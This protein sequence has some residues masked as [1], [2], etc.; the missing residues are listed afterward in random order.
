MATRQCPYCGEEIQEDAQKCRYCREWLIE[1]SPNAKNAIPAVFETE[2]RPVVLNINGSL[3]PVEPWR[4]PLARLQRQNFKFTIAILALIPVFLFGLFLVNRLVEDPVMHHNIAYYVIYLGGLLCIIKGLLSLRRYLLNFEVTSNI[5][6]LILVFI[7]ELVLI[8]IYFVVFSHHH[9][10]SL[11]HDG[12]LSPEALVRI[13]LIDLFLHV[14]LFFLLAY[15]GVIIGWRLVRNVKDFVGGLDAIG[16]VIGVL[17]FLFFGFVVL[18][19]LGYTIA[20][21]YDIVTILCAVTI[22]P[23]VLIVL[24]VKAILYIKHSGYETLSGLLQSQEPSFNTIHV[25]IVMVL[26]MG[27]S[28]SCVEYEKRKKTSVIAEEF[29]PEARPTLNDSLSMGDRISYYYYMSIPEEA[30]IKTN[31]V[32]SLEWTTSTV[33]RYGGELFE[34]KGLALYSEGAFMTELLMYNQKNEVVASSYY[35]I[36]NGTFDQFISFDCIDRN[37]YEDSFNSRIDNHETWLRKYTLENSQLSD[38]IDTLKFTYTYIEDTTLVKSYLTGLLDKK[39]ELMSFD[40]GKN[41]LRKNY[42]IDGKEIKFNMNLY[43]DSSKVVGYVVKTY[44]NKGES[45]IKYDLQY[46]VDVYGNW[47]EKKATSKKNRRAILLTKRKIYY[48]N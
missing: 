14:F 44:G 41:N 30:S 46:K 1:N 34:E 18:N 9:A 3:P 16:Y 10:S 31:N 38:R 21:D 45:V 15:T 24:F 4:P 43:N 36:E 2:S 19:I 48:K 47:I 6:K 28:F 40:K 17:S 25:S 20:V 23:V 7:G 27:L 5:R 22:F 8:Y 35:T 33:D 42:F 11:F 37:F 39:Y 26:A 29:M 12:H 13:N 32:D